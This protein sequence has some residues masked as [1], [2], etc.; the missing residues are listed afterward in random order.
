[1]DTLHAPF[2]GNERGLPL[3]ILSA[4]TPRDLPPLETR[5]TRYFWTAREE[6]VLRENYPG[7]GLG[8]CIALLPGRSPSS[9]YQRAGKLG[10]RA[11]NMPPTKR[12]SWTSSKFIDDAIRRCYQAP[13]NDGVNKC[14]RS[15]GR[16]LWWVSKRA[17]TLGLVAPRFR[18]PAWS[19]PEDGIVEANSC[20]ALRTIRNALARAGFTRTET[21]I[22]TR[23]NRL[24]ASRIDPNGMSSREAGRLMGEDSHKIVLWISEGWLKARRQGTERT[25]AQGGDLWKI[26]R[27]DLYQ[28][29]VD[30][31]AQVDLRKVDKFWFIDL[32]A[33]RGAS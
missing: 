22:R 9:I 21:A 27:G 12:P 11:P 3:D 19:E 4:R 5:P 33:S 13:T 25:E 23:I 28:F 24:G 26:K 6:K 16:P 30:N 17:V 2:D 20:R 14:A 1:M 18:E 8:G 10:L 31:A 7:K 32:M 15:I 29:I